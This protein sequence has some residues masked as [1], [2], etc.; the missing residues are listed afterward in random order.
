MTCDRH[1]PCTRDHDPVP[2]GGV[3]PERVPVRRGTV[4]AWLHPDAPPDYAG[5]SPAQAEALS[6]WDPTHGQARP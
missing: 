6:T 5:L 1:D 3:P 2:E 4:A